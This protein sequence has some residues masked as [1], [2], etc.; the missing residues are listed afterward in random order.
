MST[1][2]FVVVAATC[3]VVSVRVLA[4]SALL[5]SPA[6]GVAGLLPLLA[7]S[8]ARWQWQYGDDVQERR[9]SGMAMPAVFFGVAL[10]V[11][12]LAGFANS[13]YGPGAAL[14]IGGAALAGWGWWAKRRSN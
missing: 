11:A 1:R 2:T 14:L 7:L 8:I 12:A 10:C 13:R 3:L 9:S 4:A 6:L 5:D